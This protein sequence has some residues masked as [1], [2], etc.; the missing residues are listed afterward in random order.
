MSNAK[1]D[2]EAEAEIVLT[3]ETEP[4]ADPDGDDADDELVGELLSA[5]LE[6]QTERDS[7]ERAQAEER[8]AKRIDGVELGRLVELSDQGPRVTYPSCP[9]TNGLVARCAAQLT[10]AHVGGRVA[11]LFENGDPALPMVVG[12]IHND[13]ALDAVDHPAL[14]GL[15]IREDENRIEIQCHKA[16]GLNVGKSTIV[17]T[18]AGR[19][20]VRGRHVLNHASAVNRIRGATVKIN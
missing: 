19:I 2:D 9:T 13:Q 5:V 3:L 7:R 15:T 20:I 16:I 4:D 11:L 10:D 6:V 14:K 18:P 17:I 12:P 8:A 1:P